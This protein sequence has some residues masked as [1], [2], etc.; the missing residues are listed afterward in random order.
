MIESTAF[1]LHQF[2]GCYRALNHRPLPVA[3]PAPV[4]L[5][6][7]DRGTVWQIIEA[8]PP[9]LA[10]CTH[11]NVGAH[12][13]ACRDCDTW[14]DVEYWPAEQR[15]YGLSKPA[16]LPQDAALWERLHRQWEQTTGRVYGQV[17]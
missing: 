5:Y 15:G 13:A 4:C 3:P 9:Y 7:R 11:C 17:L 1:T 12:M 10:A 16:Y 14:H 8:A 6:C 2:P